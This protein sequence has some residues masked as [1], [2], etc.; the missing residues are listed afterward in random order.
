MYQDGDL[1]SSAMPSQISRYTLQLLAQHVQ[2]VNRT[3]TMTMKN[4]DND[5]DNDDG[6]SDDD[7]NDDNDAK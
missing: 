6:D 1:A 3:M 7:E 2:Y 5:D 4:D